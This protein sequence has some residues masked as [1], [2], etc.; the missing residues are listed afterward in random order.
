MLSA[1]GTVIR[2]DVQ[3]A[4]PPRSAPTRDRAA[5]ADLRPHGRTWLAGRTTLLAHDGDPAGDRVLRGRVVG[6]SVDDDSV[7]GLVLTS[8]T[9]CT[10]GTRRPVGRDGTVTSRDVYDALVVRG[11]DF[12]CTS[13]GI[14]ALDGRTGEQVWEAKA[15]A[16]MSSGLATDGR[17][18]LLLSVAGGASGPAGVTSYDLATGER[19]RALGPGRRR[20]A[21][22]PRRASAGPDGEVRRGRTPE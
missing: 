22:G 11:R 12:L 7:P 4:V 21:P 1:T 6:R 14:A 16:C 5:D 19:R 9:S 2:Q 20:R 8:R 17:D 15:P 13:S 10:R 18:L 3:A